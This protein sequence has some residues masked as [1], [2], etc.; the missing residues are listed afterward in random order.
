MTSS[1]YFSW[2]QSMALVQLVCP[3]TAPQ[4]ALGDFITAQ[5]VPDRTCRNLLFAGFL[6]TLMTASVVGTL[7]ESVFAG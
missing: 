4:L 6:A 1:W 7:P 5:A 3:V 2:P